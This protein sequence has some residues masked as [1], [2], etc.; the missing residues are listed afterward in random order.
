MHKSDGQRNLVITGAV[1]LLVFLFLFGYYNV[2]NSFS[3]KGNASNAET[4]ETKPIS[5]SNFMLNTVV[6]ITIYDSSD[7][8]IIDG[9][10]DVI[11]KYEKIYSRTLETSEVYKL[12]HRSLQSD[13]DKK[14]S[15]RISD[16]LTDILKK[17]LYYSELTDGKF[18]ITIA[19]VSSLWDF[20]SENPIVPDKEDLKRA[21]RNVGYQNIELEGNTITLKNSKSSFDLGAIAKG[22]I[23]DK[24]KE[25][26]VDQG[27][28]SAMINLGGNVLCVGEKTNGQAFRVGIQKPFADR[29]EIV[30]TM[31]INDKS[32]VSSGIYERCFT[33]NGKFYHH[34]LNP[35]TGYS[36][37]NNLISVTIISPL[38]ADGDGL[39]TSCF[40]L[41][42]EEGMKLINSL[43]NVQAI[44]IT[45]DY[46]LHYSEGFFDKIK[47]TEMQ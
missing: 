38:S 3:N 15:Y 22:Y 28:K 5:K 29:N 19:P 27:V 11:S 30:A 46:K 12:N 41:G 2:S 21:I 25:Y 10:M 37:D 32:V 13:A 7:T 24:V 43:E 36:Y 33:S 17:G 45:D 16:E 47:V 4:T 26:L 42:L 35:K 23:A 31:E 8:S 1:V 14:I 44:F 39:S 20:T 18:D 34:I 40:A 6:T 9:A